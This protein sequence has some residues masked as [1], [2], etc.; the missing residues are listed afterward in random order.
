MD[1]WKWAQEKKNKPRRKVLGRCVKNN[2]PTTINLKAK[3][4]KVASL[5]QKQDANPKQVKIHLKMHFFVTQ[6]TQT[7]TTRKLKKGSGSVWAGPLGPHLTLNLP[8]QSLSNK[9]INSPNKN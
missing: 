6:K 5:E 3:T 9:K 7:K 1:V 2:E 4:I 8:K